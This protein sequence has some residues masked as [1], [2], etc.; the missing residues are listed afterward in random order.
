[1]HT[2]FNE[3]LKRQCNFESLSAIIM[4]VEAGTAVDRVAFVVHMA[5]IVDDACQCDWCC[6][7]W[8]LFLATHIYGILIQ[9]YHSLEF[10]WRSR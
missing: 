1:M 4:Y 3:S 2:C 9:T 5:L 8:I 6:H 7:T 10:W